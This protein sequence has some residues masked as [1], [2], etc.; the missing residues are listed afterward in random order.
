MQAIE[1]LCEALSH[2]AYARE[3]L[4][5]TPKTRRIAWACLQ[6]RFADSSIRRALK[7]LKE[8]NERP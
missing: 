7:L 6:S 8:E 3:N 4:A 1:E 2:L 5:N